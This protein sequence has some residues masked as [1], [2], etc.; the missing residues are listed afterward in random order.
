M[1]CITSDQAQCDQRK[2]QGCVN[3]PGL[4][5]AT[6]NEITNI[7]DVNL[8]EENFCHPYVTIDEDWSDCI[9]STNKQD[10]L[11]KQKCL[12]STGK[13]FAQGGDF[14]SPIKVPQSTQ[15]FDQCGSFKE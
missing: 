4:I 7:D 2:S 6:N 3:F 8:F 12:W 9:S 5:E 1:T 10:C 11:G 13:G 14:C 15:D